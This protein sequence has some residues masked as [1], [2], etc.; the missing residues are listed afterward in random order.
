MTTIRIKPENLKEEI[1]QLKDLQARF[2]EDQLTY[3]SLEGS[4]ETFEKMQ[5]IVDY[6][7]ASE[8]RFVGLIS[9]TISF[10]EATREQFETVDFEI[11]DQLLNS[12]NDD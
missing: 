10:L 5:E 8:A 7:R 2:I 4:G 12:G 3:P 6:H 11:S 9:N 1:N